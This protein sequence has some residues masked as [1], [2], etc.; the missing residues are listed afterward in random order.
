MSNF[1]NLLEKRRSI[2]AIGNDLPLSE[3]AV[4][5]LIQS[6]VK[7]SPSAFNSQTSR[8][9]ILM[10]DAHQKLWNI[11]ENTLKP[12]TPAEAFPNTQEKLAS[13]A[14]GKGTILFFEDTDVVK[15]LQEQ[16]ALYA[17]N[18]PIWSDHSTGIAQHS[19]WVALA[20]ANIGAS[21]QHYN[22]II[23]DEVAATWNIPAS[24]K[25]TAQMPFGS[26]KAEAGEK[27]FMADDARFMVIK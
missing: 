13:F 12:L 7:A 18:F 14:A 11:V 16:F 1:I 4:T 23:D 8:V 19:V 9:V 20:E 24:W 10:G 21:L 3:D 15:S 6:A 26:I 22:P 25:L 5:A 17:D 27:E 2:Y